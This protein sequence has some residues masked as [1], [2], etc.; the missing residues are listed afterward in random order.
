LPELDLPAEP[1]K[2][3]GGLG[4]DEPCVYANFV[5]TTDGIVAISELPRSNALIAGKSE[6]D[7]RLCNRRHIHKDRLG[8]RRRVRANQPY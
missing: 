1:R 8:N 4:F 5:Q 7:N 3:Y 6:S 2:L